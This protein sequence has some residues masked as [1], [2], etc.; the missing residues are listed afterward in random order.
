MLKLNLWPCVF[1]SKELQKNM[2]LDH[3]STGVGRISKLQIWLFMSTQKKCHY[4]FK[5]K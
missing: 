1:G 4:L 3:K 2:A 5:K